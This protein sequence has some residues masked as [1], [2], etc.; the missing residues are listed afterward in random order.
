MPTSRSTFLRATILQFLPIVPPRSLGTKGNVHPRWSG[1]SKRK[2]HGAK[3]ELVHIENISQ[4]VA[5]VSKKVTA[6]GIASGPVQIVIPLHQPLKLALNIR[7]LFRWKFVF[8]QS[9]LGSLKVPKEASL[10]RS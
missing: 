6:V 3:V 2:A 10:L 4:R 7:N 1:K 9:Y 5:G 8:V